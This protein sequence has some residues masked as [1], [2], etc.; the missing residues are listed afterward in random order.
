M[1]IVISGI[2]TVKSMLEKYRVYF[3]MDSNFRAKRRYLGL[4]VYGAHSQKL[5]DAVENAY[6]AF[7]VEYDELLKLGYSPK[8]LLELTT[9][10]GAHSLRQI[11]R[12][13]MR[14]YAARGP[15]VG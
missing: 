9:D 15:V 3:H 12:H 2:V 5:R 11:D 7:R 1:E 13:L 6:D 14:R 4:N 8:H 10:S